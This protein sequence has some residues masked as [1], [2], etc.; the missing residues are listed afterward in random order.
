MAGALD[1]R[2]GEMHYVIGPS[3]NK[4]LF[5]ELLTRLEQWYVSKITK[6]YLV[7]DNYKIHKAKAVVA[8]LARRARGNSLVAQLMSQGEPD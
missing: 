7:A 6:L 1:W 4:V 8:W 5:R 2:T 3:K